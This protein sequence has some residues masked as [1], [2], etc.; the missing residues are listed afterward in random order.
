VIVEDVYRQPAPRP[1]EPAPVDPAPVAR[2]APRALPLVLADDGEA[3]AFVQEEPD[4]L[5]YDLDPDTRAIVAGVTGVVAVVA[6][7]LVILGS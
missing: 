3:L 7:I 2:R 4:A 6:G 1:D 5:E